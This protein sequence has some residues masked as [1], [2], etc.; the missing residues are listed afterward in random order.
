MAKRLQIFGNLFNGF[1]K[2]VNGVGPDSNGN[3]DID[4]YSSEEDLPVIPVNKLNNIYKNID[5]TV[6]VPFDL[7]DV[8]GLDKANVAPYG[9]PSYIYKVTD[10]LPNF[11]Y[12]DSVA[13]KELVSSQEITYR[14]SKNSTDKTMKLIC[15]EYAMH[16]YGNTFVFASKAGDI[17]LSTYYDTT[18]TYNFPSPG[19]YITRKLLSLNYH[20]YSIRKGIYINSST[21]KK[22]LITVDDTGTIS[23]TE[24]TT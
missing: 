19:L 7:S 4:A 1:V 20:I 17:T 21:D 9:S 8:N 23:A 2:K 16:N 13:I 15:D 10:E 18:V 6:S 24:V 14:Y 5:E 3:V 11:S 12:V 22:F